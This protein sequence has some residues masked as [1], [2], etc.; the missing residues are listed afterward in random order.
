MAGGGTHF[1][2]NPNSKGAGLAKNGQRLF[3]LGEFV[4]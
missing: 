4:F 1:E 3:E 2:V